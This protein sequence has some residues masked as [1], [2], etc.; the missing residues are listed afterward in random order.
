MMLLLLLL[1]LLLLRLAMLLLLGGRCW[2][3]KVVIVI[4][5]VE[6]GMRGRLLDLRDL[7]HDL[8]ELGRA[9][10]LLLG[11]LGN[12]VFE[13]ARIV[14]RHLGLFFHNHVFRKIDFPVR[15]FLY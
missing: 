11:Q 6:D 5:V 10:R 2:A 9:L 4:A 13:L 7:S 15:S 8:L 3:A 1:L 12:P 14:G